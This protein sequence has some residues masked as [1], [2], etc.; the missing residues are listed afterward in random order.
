MKTQ[1]IKEMMLAVSRELI[2]KENML[3]ELDSF[4]GDGDHGVT[5]ARGFGEV[6]RRLEQE[7][8]TYPAEIF[9][10]VGQTLSTAMGG[11]IGPLIGS[12]FQAGGKKIENGEEMDE[13]DFVILFEEGLKRVQLLGGAQEGDRTMVDAMA[14]AVRA[15]RQTYER[16]SIIQQIFEEA[17]EAAHQG[18]EHTSQLTAKKGRARFLGE[19]SLGYVDAGATTF[20]LL[21]NRMKE[22]ILS[23]A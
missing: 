18:A 23:A 1:E 3:C 15:M 9:Q 7:T 14:P 4:I 2:E 10:L 6:E 22:Y 13:K 20:Y 21:I 8:F 17:A 11:A 16:G 19:K 12:F 5:V